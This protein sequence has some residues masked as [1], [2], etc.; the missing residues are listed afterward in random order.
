VFNKDII[1]KFNSLNKTFINK[2]LS[3]SLYN[4]LINEVYTYYNVE[5]WSCDFSHKEA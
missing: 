4:N 1:A 3:L 2:I 5:N